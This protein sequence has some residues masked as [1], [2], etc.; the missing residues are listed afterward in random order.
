[1]TCSSNQN[2]NAKHGSTWPAGSIIEMFGERLRIRENWGSS[3]EVER[4][5]GDFVSNKY[6][7]QFGEEKAVLITKV[8]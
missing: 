3:G 6:Y 8:N 5:N 4:L 1:M 7:W 2:I